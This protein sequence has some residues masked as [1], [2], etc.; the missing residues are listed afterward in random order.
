MGRLS[1]CLTPTPDVHNTTTGSFHRPVKFKKKDLIKWCI[2]RSG[3]KSMK[4]CRYL[5]FWICFYI[6]LLLSYINKIRG[7]IIS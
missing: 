1:C 3:G 2:L 6:I 5:D 4:C 7:L